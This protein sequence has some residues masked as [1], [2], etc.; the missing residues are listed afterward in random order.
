MYICNALLKHGYPNFSL[1]ILEYC[2]PEKCL[3]RE[4]HYLD[5]LQPEYNIS[6][7]P[8]A[9]MLGRKH[10]DKTLKKI[11]WRSHMCPFRHQGE[12]HPMFEKKA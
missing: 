6:L 12:N 5:I 1:T 7:N 8:T 2:S 10:S 4:K 9:P 3:E 11:S